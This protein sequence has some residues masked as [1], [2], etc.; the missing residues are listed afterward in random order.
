MKKIFPIIVLLLTV[1]AA[2]SQ[3]LPSPP[4]TFTTITQMQTYTGTSQ[5]A[6]LLDKDYGG[7]FELVHGKYKAD[8]INL[9][10]TGMKRKYW[11]REGGDIS[12]EKVTGVAKINS[13]PLLSK[14]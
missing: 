11:H 5:L 4:I 10:K 7:I 3:K 12:K 6:V 1:F 8:G 13:L 2:H 9:I 14:I